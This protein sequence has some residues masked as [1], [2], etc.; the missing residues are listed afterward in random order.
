MNLLLFFING[1]VF[2]T[3]MYAQVNQYAVNWFLIFG[4][5]FSAM[6][7]TWTFGEGV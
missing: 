6:V 1:L 4:M 7:I 2:I 3:C 5:V